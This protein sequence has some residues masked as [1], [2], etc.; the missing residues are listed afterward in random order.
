MKTKKNICPIK[1]LRVRAWYEGIKQRSN[2]T[3]PHQIEKLI[4]NKIPTPLHPDTPL[5]NKWRRYR[6]GIE[7][8]RQK[9]VQNVDVV[10]PGSAREFNHPL[11]EILLRGDQVISDIDN[12]ME[13]LEPKVQFAVFGQSYEVFPVKSRQPFSSKIG[14]E[15]VK[16]G[17]I[18]ALAAILLYW[19]ESKQLGQVNNTQNQAQ[20]MYRLLLMLGLELKERN[21]AEDL[22]DLILERVFDRTNWGTNLEFGIN[23]SHYRRA[24]NLL[25]VMLYKFPELKAFSSRKT[26]SSA[27]HLLLE[28]KRG[29]SISCGL[30][31]VL[32]PNWQFGP[33]TEG[34]WN[35]WVRHY[36][37]WLWGWTHLNRTTIGYYGEDDIWKS[38]GL[39][40]LSSRG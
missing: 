35:S 32:T 5:R 18:D 1:S 29:L 14:R 6:L 20:Y 37:E 22:F 19:I 34:E 36:K 15:L 3:N 23:Y 21:L 38:L 9:F 24:F 2:C 28:G 16:L 10:F 30:D 26:C 11:W 7:V 8:P 33:P 39:N 12:W 13:K 27:M 31:V 40:S 4:E 17:N 25:N